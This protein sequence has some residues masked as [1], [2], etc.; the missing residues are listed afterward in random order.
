MLWLKLQQHK[1]HSH[2]HTAPHLCTPLGMSECATLNFEYS[3]AKAKLCN[4]VYLYLDG[5]YSTVKGIRET[6]ASHGVIDAGLLL[7]LFNFLFTLSFPP[8][9]CLLNYMCTI[10]AMAWQSNYR[11][12]LRV[13]R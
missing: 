7:N 8:Q 9:Q 6:S 5:K 12:S 3:L 4:L 11:D 10:S 1:V 2:L 13:D